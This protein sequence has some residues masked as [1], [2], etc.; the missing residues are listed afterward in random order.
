MLGAV[1]RSEL[2]GRTLDRC[3]RAK[4]ESQTTT[5][6][7]SE[8]FPVRARTS[9]RFEWEERVPPRAPATRHRSCDNP[10]LLLRIRPFLCE[11]FFLAKEKRYLTTTN[12][13]P[14]NGNLSFLSLYYKHQVPVSDCHLPLLQRHLAQRRASRGPLCQAPA[15]RP[16]RPSET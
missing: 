13:L 7:R 15:G 4:H 1:A 14:A 3:Y 8:P 5:T 2:C 10:V 11:Y 6:Q 16:V 9:Q 12:L